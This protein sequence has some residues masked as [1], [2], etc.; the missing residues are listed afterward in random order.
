MQHVG[1]SAYEQQDDAVAEET[2]EPEAEASADE[3]D[4]PKDEEVLE[5]EFTEE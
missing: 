3:H 4:L 2:T 5:G 1:T